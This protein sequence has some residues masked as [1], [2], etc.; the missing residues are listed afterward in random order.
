MSTLLLTVLFGMVGLAVELGWAMY[1]RT[2]AQSATDAAALGSAAQALN[3]LGQGASAVCGVSVS[4]QS[5]TAC[6]ATGN[7]QNGCLYAQ[8]NGFSPGGAAGHQT[9]QIAAGTGTVPH[10]ANVPGMIYWT[11]ASAVQS[12]PALFSA[13]LNSLGLRAGAHSTAAIYPHAVTPSLYLLNRSSDCFASLLNLGVVCGEDF[14]SLLGSTVNARGGIY[15]SSSNPQGTALPNV[16]AATIVGTADVTSPFTYVMGNGGVNTLGT[17]NW[18]SAPRNGFAD[19]EDFR[20]PMRGKGQPPAPT[21]LPDHPVPGGVIAGGLLGGTVTLP[22]GKY[23][24]SDPLTGAP[25]GTPIVIAGNVTFSDGGTP[26]CGGFCNY[27][28]FGGLATG[29]LTTTTFSP[30][31]YVFAGAQPVSGG[32][33]VALMAGVNA[34]VKDMTPLSNGQIT[35]NSD[36][37]E[38]FIFT[39]SSYAGLQL[40]AAIKNAGLSF[41][42]VT[43]GF[44]GGL[45]F[46]VTLHG[47]NANASALPSDLNSFAPV[48]FWQDQANTTLSYNADG[49]LNTA[50]GSVCSHVLSVPGSQQMIIGA[51]QAGGQPSVNLL[52]TIYA[53]RGAWTTLLGVLPGDTIRGPL[54]II[55]GSLQMAVNTTLDVTPLPNPPTR[56]TVSLIQ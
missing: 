53:P 1:V 35:Q 38:I 21:G 25:L 23:F 5:M 52:G 8:Q 7:I 32:P 49:S 22:P 19:G 43:A 3:T 12:L 56:L 17:S 11:Q 48:L 36:A 45:G 30:G 9:L 55:T 41:P 40:P 54:Q 10:V 42:Q 29:A 4:C 14:L 2:M 37:G 34:V 33:G 16:A 39:D 24:A 31:R 6:P 47:L 20:D 50:C 26:P 27:M 44:Q 18:T 15:M 46:S 28:F 13:V 51:A